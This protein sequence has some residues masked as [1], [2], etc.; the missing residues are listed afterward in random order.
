MNRATAMGAAA[1]GRRRKG[2]TAN[3]VGS[4]ASLV[5]ALAPGSGPF[6]SVPDAAVALAAHDGARLRLAPALVTGTVVRASDVLVA[7]RT[8]EGEV[9]STPEH[10]FAR[11][12]LG[13][14]LRWVR[15]SRLAAGDSLVRW[16]PGASVTAVLSVRETHGRPVPVFNLAISHVHAY[17]VG[18]SHLLVHNGRC[19]TTPEQIE[20]EKRGLEDLLAKRTRL[21]NDGDPD[22]ELPKLRAEIRTLRK[23]LAQLDARADPAKR[24]AVNQASLEYARKRRAENPGAQSAARR[25]RWLRD[26]ALRDRYLERARARRRVRMQTGREEY[27]RKQVARY[28]RRNAALRGLEESRGNQTDAEFQSKLKE[29]HDLLMAPGPTESMEGI[30]G[31][32]RSTI[33]EFEEELASGSG[34]S[35]DLRS[36]AQQDLELASDGLREEIDEIESSIA[37]I[38]ALSE[39]IRTYF[40]ED[41]IK[42]RERQARL[43]QERRIIAELDAP[44]DGPGAA[45]GVSREALQQEMTELEALLKEPMDERGPA[46][47]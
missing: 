33:R 43:A 13:D 1:A 20:A 9:V 2:C 22:K 41:L 23:R 36:S 27:N 11:A 6:G 16:S 34:A 4:V 15:A 30:E 40:V 24:A 10:P 47:P 39:D 12:G 46:S 29:M 14:G 44:L 21:T 45:E 42:L 5:L 8:A 35:A 26:P 7:V 3:G 19:R 37:G 17:L 25:E 32:L 18:P 31:D 38:E 28:H